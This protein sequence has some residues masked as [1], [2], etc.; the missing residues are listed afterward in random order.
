MAVWIGVT[1]V[2]AAGAVWFAEPSISVLSR[3]FAAI[4]TRR[5]SGDG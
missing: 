1:T 4:G 3:Y 2:L 5:A